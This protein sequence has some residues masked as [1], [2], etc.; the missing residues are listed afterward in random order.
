MPLSLKEVQYQWASIQANVYL[1]G[2]QSTKMPRRYFAGCKTKAHM[3]FDAVQGLL[4]LQS[5][6]EQVELQSKP[7]KHRDKASYY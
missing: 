4:R 1:V 3:D 7:L 6:K 5:A 2:T